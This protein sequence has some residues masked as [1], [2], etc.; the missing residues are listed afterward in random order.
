MSIDQIQ[1]FEHQFSTRLVYGRGQL[2]RLTAL[3]VELGGSGARVFLVTGRHSLKANGAFDR[4][5]ELLASYPVVTFDEVQS[6]P[7][8]EVAERALARCRGGGCSIV[9]GVGGGSCL[10]VGKIT[11]LISP[12]KGQPGDYLQDDPPVTAA[13]LPLI[14]VPTTSGS[15]SE[16]TPFTVVWDAEAKKRYPFVH[17]LLAPAVALVDPD[18]AQSMSGYL[19]AVTGMDALTSACEAYWSI[20]SQPVSDTLAL[21]AI[22]LYMENLE[23]SCTEGTPPS[24]R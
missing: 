18:L 14:A 19:A 2:S 16:V 4:I 9:V 17:P 1:G 20:G 13:G 5:N 22:R 11:A 21:R 24:Q 15:S 23:A 3:V 10:D 6:S 12:N 7:S 8:P